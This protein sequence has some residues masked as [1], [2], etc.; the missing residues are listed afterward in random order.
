[1]ALVNPALPS[2]VTRVRLWASDTREVTGNVPPMEVSH[3]L[4][5][6][7]LVP[8]NTVTSVYRI[9]WYM[10]C[11]KRAFMVSCI[12]RLMMVSRVRVGWDVGIVVGC[13]VGGLV[14]PGVVGLGVGAYENLVGLAVG[15]EVGRL[16]G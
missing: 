1:M 16:V 10:L 7:L 13:P 11:S 8:P 3:E 2:Y 14:C 9:S 12:L 4:H 5:P 15:C 6:P